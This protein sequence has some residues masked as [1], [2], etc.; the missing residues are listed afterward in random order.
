MIT[1]IYTIGLVHVS[2]PKHQIRIK[3]GASLS[4]VNNHQA[5]GTPK[6][7]YIYI[8]IYTL[9]NRTERVRGQAGNTAFMGN[10]DNVIYMYR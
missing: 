8:Y 2:G 4:C 6:P 1:L 5:P 9:D 10:G 3:G 7:I